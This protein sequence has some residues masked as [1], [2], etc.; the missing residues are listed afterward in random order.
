MVTRMLTS[1]TGMRTVH[2]EA[3]EL[4]L[5]QPGIREA[6]PERDAA[7]HGDL[8]QQDQR[9]EHAHVVGIDVEAGEVPAAEEQRGRD[10]GERAHRRELA[11]EEQQEPQAGVLGDVAGDQ[12]GFGDRHVERGLGELGLAGDQEHAEPDDLGEEERAADRFPTEDLA[13][14]LHPHHLLQVERL[15]LDDHADHRDQRS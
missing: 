11:D 1:D 15:G 12:L 4:V 7:E 14:G 8:G 3:L 13:V 5:A 10:G 6:D 2:G 9:A